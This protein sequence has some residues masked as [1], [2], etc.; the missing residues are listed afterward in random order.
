MR[1]S[2]QVSKMP[3]IGIKGSVRFIV[4]LTYA[5]IRYFLIYVIILLILDSK[6]FNQSYCTAV[7]CQDKFLNVW[8]KAYSQHEVTKKMYHVPKLSYSIGTGIKTF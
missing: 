3:K 1:L 8:L 2:H 5:L 6:L 4:F 7:L